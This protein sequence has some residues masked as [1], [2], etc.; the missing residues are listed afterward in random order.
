MRSDQWYAPEDFLD[1]LEN[2]MSRQAVVRDKKV[3]H[4]GVTLQS[5][6]DGN[7]TVTHKG[8]ELVFTETE[9]ISLVDTASN[10]I[11]WKSVKE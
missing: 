2:D 6:S 11:E 1:H 9:F 10:V 4:R 3:T 5:D 8:T 7:V